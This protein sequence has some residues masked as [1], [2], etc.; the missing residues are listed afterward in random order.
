MTSVHTGDFPSGSL[1]TFRSWFLDEFM[2]SGYDP[3]LLG[4]ITGLGDDTEK[5]TFPGMI[6]SLRQWTGNRQVDGAAIYE[7]DILVEKYEKTLEL[8]PFDQMS[9][10]EKTNAESLIRQLG[11]VTARFA[12]ERFI[13]LLNNGF[14]GLAFDGQFFY[15]T[16]HASRDS[17]TQINTTSNSLTS[18]NL[19]TAIQTMLGYKDDRGKPLYIQPSH[20]LVSPSSRSTAKSILES[21]RLVLAGN[22]DVNLPDGNTNKNELKLIV[23]PNVTAFNW[24][25]LALEH[26][27]HKPLQGRWRNEPKFDQLGEGSDHR[28]H[29]DTDLYGVKTEWAEGYGLWYLAYG[30]SATS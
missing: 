9:A 30:S 15:D 5:I 25:V 18:G 11:A 13:E 8:K 21:D 6:S 2:Q 22:T 14:T 3:G 26:G 16:D 17:G 29:N 19:T 28:F 12:W 10:I 23:D 7:I 4:F 27:T 1:T 24:H 20:L